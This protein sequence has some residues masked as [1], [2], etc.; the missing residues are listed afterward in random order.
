MGSALACPTPHIL[1]FIG[2]YKGA[3]PLRGPPFESAPHH[4]FFSFFL[5]LGPRIRP[6]DDFRL[7]GIGE[8]VTSIILYQNKQLNY[9]ATTAQN[10]CCCL[11]LLQDYQGLVSMGICV[12]FSAICFPSPCH[13]GALFNI[14]SN[15]ANHIKEIS[16]PSTSST[17]RLTRCLLSWILVRSAAAMRCVPPV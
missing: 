4:F 10:V 17:L 6:F 15:I 2:K 1:P 9:S 12:R 11:C 7:I 3:F 8:P 13:R 5:S 16:L 14:A